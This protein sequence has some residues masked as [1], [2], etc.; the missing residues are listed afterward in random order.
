MADNLIDKFVQFDNDN[1]DVWELFVQFTFE[2]INK[3]R[4]R[5]GARGVFERIRWETALQTTDPVYKLN[6]HWTPYYAR[7]FHAVYPEHDGFFALR[8]S[9]FDEEMKEEETNEEVVG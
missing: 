6:D 4:T 9:R 3:G 5:Y 8:S 1:P 7:K 2:M